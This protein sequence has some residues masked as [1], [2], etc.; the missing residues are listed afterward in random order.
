MV[1]NDLR[2]NPPAPAGRATEVLT[3]FLKLGLLSFG[4]PVAHVG[5][6]HA[7]F[8]NRRRW[9]DDESFTD[10]VALCQ[11][12]PGP[13][14]SQLGF[15]LGLMR[16]GYLGGLAAWTGFTLPSAILMVLAARVADIATGPLAVGVIH[17]L[18]LRCALWHKRSGQWRVRCV[19]TGNAP[20]WRWRPGSSC[21]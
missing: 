6:F 12:L 4:G 16:A 11:F 7:E 13:A 2:E 21:W 10:L 19:R 17:G 14:S 18:K 1:P 9:L 20:R 15:S 8:V 5:Y 3:A